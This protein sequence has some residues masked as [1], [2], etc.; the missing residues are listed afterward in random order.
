MR[1]PAFAFLGAAC[2]PDVEG[3]GAERVGVKG[4]SHFARESLLLTLEALRSPEPAAFCPL[5]QE[6]V[7]ELLTACQRLPGIL[8]ETLSEESAADP[9][10]LKP[11]FAAVIGPA[12]TDIRKLRQRAAH[13]AFIH[14]PIDGIGGGNHGIAQEDDDSLTNTEEFQEPGIEPE[15]AREHNDETSDISHPPRTVRVGS[16]GWQQKA[17]PT[18]LELSKQSHALKAKE[19]ALEQQLEPLR[20]EPKLTDETIDLERQHAKVKRQLAPLRAAEA[21]ARGSRALE[22]ARDTVRAYGPILE[23]VVRAMESSDRM[24]KVMGRE[25]PARDFFHLRFAS[26]CVSLLAGRKYTHHE[27]DQ[28]L[29]DLEEVFSPTDDALTGDAVIIFSGL[30]GGSTTL[31]RAHVTPA[32]SDD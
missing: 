9:P 24:I 8:L 28:M 2:L 18:P 14:V 12:R 6:A 11:L 29:R 25:L 27:R 15:H 13:P 4:Y 10:R 1:T 3:H 32:I 22:V 23:A 30:V 20:K 26:Q 19:E 21:A 31:N 7:D 17:E 5:I 16:Q